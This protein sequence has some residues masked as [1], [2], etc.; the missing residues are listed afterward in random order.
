MTDPFDV[1]RQPV[2]PVAPDPDFAETLRDELRRAVLNGETVTTT[3]AA[4]ARGYAR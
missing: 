1:L 4:P 2:R 3:E